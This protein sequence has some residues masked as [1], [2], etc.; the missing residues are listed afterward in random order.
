[1]TITQGSFGCRGISDRGKRLV[2]IK[3]VFEGG[4]EGLTRSLSR[5]NWRRRAAGIEAQ[6]S[7]RSLS[8]AGRFPV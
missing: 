1:V 4:G 5:K 2:T 3:F 8:P 7:R 6:E